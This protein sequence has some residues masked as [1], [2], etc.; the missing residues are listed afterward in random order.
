MRA[1]AIATTG[2][3]V[4]FATAPEL[5]GL[6][7]LDLIVLGQAARDVAAGL[8]LPGGGETFDYHDMSGT[9][10]AFTAAQ[11]Q[12]LYRGLRDFQTLLQRYANGDL[13]EPPQQPVVIP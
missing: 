2:C 1:A 7:G 3:R 5:S 8:G 11:V 12:G 6:Y 9:T 4:E 10:H 13:P